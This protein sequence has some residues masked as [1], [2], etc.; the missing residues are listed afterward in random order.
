MIHIF[1]IL[2]SPFN[3]ALFE[4]TADATW[5]DFE[6]VG[7]QEREGTLNVSFRDGSTVSEAE[8]VALLAAHD[9]TL[10]SQAELDADTRQTSRDRLLAARDGGT[11]DASHLDDIVSLLLG[12]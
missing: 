3:R 10:K 11:L 2:P 5:S 7:E 1:A 4:E 8:V 9:G 12:E 6:G